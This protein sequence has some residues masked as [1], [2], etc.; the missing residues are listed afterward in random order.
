M[1]TEYTLF[2]ETTVEYS[3]GRLALTERSSKFDLDYFP[4]RGDDYSPIARSLTAEQVVDVAMK[5][6]QPTLYNVEDPEKFMKD[7]IE[8]KLK[9]LF[10]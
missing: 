3:G 5:L 1:S 10:V 4:E 8:V 7:V 6:L 2:E 9:E